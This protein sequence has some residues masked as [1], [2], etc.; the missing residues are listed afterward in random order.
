MKG[1]QKVGKK[2]KAKVTF[3]E[4]K[5]AFA[6]GWYK[7]RKALE[8]IDSKIPEGSGNTLDGRS[9]ALSKNGRRDTYGTGLRKN[10]PVN[11]KLEVVGS[12]KDLKV[13]GEIADR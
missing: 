13:D 7:F 5:N 10:C 9:E 2:N 1:A 3:T 4:L 12:I 8:W 11:F 6:L